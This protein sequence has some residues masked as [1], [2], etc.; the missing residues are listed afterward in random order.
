[1]S[2][3]AKAE[4]FLELFNKGREFTEELLKENQRLR[5]RL[6]ALET[7]TSIDGTRD[8]V[9]RL[10]AEVQQVTEENRR[11]AM[12]FR[13]VEE[14]NK[15]F[16]NR[17]VEIEEQNNN[18]AN[19][20]VASYQLHSTLDFREVI[21][22]VQEIVINLVGAESFAIL[23]LDEKTN[24]LKTI[25]SEGGDVMD[26]LGAISLRL[27]DGIMGEVAKTGESYYVNQDVDGGAVTIDKPLAA[28]PLKI[29]E[30]VIGLIVIYKLL[31]QKD[32]FTAVDYELFSLLAAH[33]A[34]AIFSSK[35]YS[36][37]ERKLNTIQSFLD[38]LTTN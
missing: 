24:E 3:E 18:L 20:Y 30:H 17:Y 26:G 22:I 31:Q 11:L 14:E 5:Y 33:A 13:E 12:R 25:A 4:K 34:T 8:E 19:L 32:A 6:A 21:Q 10:R 38:L 35:L 36:Q 7:E 16:A 28:V 2:D 27:G 37:S 15:D 23:L 9:D 1:M 29:K